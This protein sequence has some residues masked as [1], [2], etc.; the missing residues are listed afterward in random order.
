MRGMLPRQFTAEFR[1]EAVCKGWQREGCPSW[2]IPMLEALLKEILPDYP[3]K[4]CLSPHLSI[5]V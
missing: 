1:G 5:S 3:G 4:F 2:V